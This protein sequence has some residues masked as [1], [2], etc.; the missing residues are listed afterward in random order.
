M[1]QVKKTKHFYNKYMYTC[2]T[3]AGSDYQS[4][5]QRFTLEQTPSNPI[6]QGSITVRSIDDDEIEGNEFIGVRIV[7]PP[8]FQDIVRTRTPQRTIEIIDND[9]NL[10][11]TTI[12]SLSYY[13]AVQRE[14]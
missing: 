6:P 11:S 4:V 12:P 9:G 14:I 7:I 2:L 13:C 5:S 1:Q 3:I 8:E 10:V